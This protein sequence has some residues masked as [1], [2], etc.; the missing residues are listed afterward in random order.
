MKGGVA[1]MM[2]AAKTIAQAGVGLDGDL[3][4]CFTAGEETDN[5]GAAETVE[6]YPFGEIQAIFIS[7]PSNNEIVTAEKGA[8]WLEITTYGRSAHTSQMDESR[9]ALSMML[10]ILTELSDIN[11][12]VEPHPLLGNFLGSINTLHAGTK[13][14]TIPAQCVATIDYRTLPGQVHSEILGR[15]EAV[16]E[17]VSKGAGLPDFRAQVRAV[18][19]NPPLE[20]PPDDPVLEPL[21]HIAA[22]VNGH[23]QDSPKGVG[24]FTDAVKFAPALRAP[25]AV[26]GPGDP[27][28]NHRSNEWVE[29]RRL[30]ESVRI[31]TIAAL[32]YLR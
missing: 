30:E 31:Y 27:T 17:R 25:F 16:V 18:L 26:C 10:P 5:L 11:L 23:A 29:I 20:V 13:T 19:D 32:E 14:N 24:F 22:E 21:F 7:E 28:L 15:V 3:Y 9:N 12:N 8:L 6:R 1:A 2:V 4:L